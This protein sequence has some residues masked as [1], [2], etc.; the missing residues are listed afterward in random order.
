M[1]LKKIY[2]LFG[3][4]LVI[5]FLNPTS[6]FSGCLNQPYLI[7]VSS[8]GS[9][10]GNS[11]PPS[12]GKINV[13]SD[14][15]D[16]PLEFKI[17]FSGQDCGFEN[18]DIKIRLFKT[19]DFFDVDSISLAQTPKGNM[20]VA[21]K[22]F[23]GRYS[24]SS[25]TQVDIDVKGSRSS[26]YLFPDDDGPEIELID[27]IENLYRSGDDIS[28]N[29]NINDYG[30]L[31]RVIF[32]G[33]Y[34]DSFSVGDSSSFN[35]RINFTIG[36]TQTLVIRARDILGNEVTKKYNFTVDSQGPVISK[37]DKA[38]I[39][40]GGERG[41]N[42]A[43]EVS[44]NS[45]SSSRDIEI[46][47]N[48]SD[49]NSD[50][51][52]LK[53]HRCLRDEVQ[54]DKFNCYWN[55]LAINVENTV[56]ADIRIWA[57]DVVGNENTQTFREEIY[58]DNE[59]PKILA[60]EVVNYLGNKNIISSIE[61]R[62]TYVYLK[63]KDRS[64][65]E[66]N[67]GGLLPEVKFGMLGSPLNSAERTVNGDTI[68]YVWNIT[69]ISRGFMGIDSGK[70]EFSV[71]VVDPYSNVASKNI[72]VI[73]DNIIPGI[74]SI[75]FLETES[76][77]DGVIKS[78]ERVNFKVIVND[79]NLDYGR[80]D[81]NVYSD[82]Y[83][84]ST[85]HKSNEKVMADCGSSRSEGSLYVCN[86]NNVIA[87]NGYELEN[88]SFFAVDKAGNGVVEKF[89]VEILKIA[90]ETRL[91]YEIIDLNPIDSSN[92]ANVLNIMNPINRNHLGNEVVDAWFYGELKLKDGDEA[93]YTILNYDLRECYFVDEN[94][95]LDVGD[96]S[97]YPPIRNGVRNDSEFGLKIEML[98]HPAFEDMNSVEMMCIMSILKRDADSIYGTE[99]EENGE[100]L[101]FTLKIDFYAEPSGDIVMRKA[102][103]VKEYMD[104]ADKV[105]DII[106]DFWDV[107][108]TMDK[109]C[110]TVS[111]FST[112]TDKIASI[113][114]GL[115]LIKPWG[116]TMRGAATKMNGADGSLKSML[117]TGVINGMCKFVSCDTGLLELTGNVNPVKEVLENMQHAVSEFA[118]S[119]TYNDE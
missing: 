24:I 3:F 6:A 90:D 23:F 5:S 118:C 86:F 106:G 15:S 21:T 19:G 27:R 2:Y 33:P 116:E 59:A 108:E 20:S 42:I 82:L 65:L 37:L 34:S 35:K 43:V 75:E 76:I 64:L 69:E 13:K 68:E 30:L 54:R 53:A 89:E 104:N 70:E 50:F 46:Y 67:S 10:A 101:N 72:N 117:N 78:G 40:D 22:T 87:E 1:S 77:E 115:A 32:S 45:F 44:D 110:R 95:T 7:E 85:N 62:N 58:V 61:R 94:I 103:R 114:N 31:D 52:N 98:N 47:G 73:I 71:V 36:S 66:E 55:N 18:S 91:V 81:F 88:V 57:R 17:I 8:G 80:R 14:I 49:F 102:Q 97:F 99:L 41:V 105:E 12:I 83:L 16:N 38:Y 48:F 107:Y 29:F 56:K 96:E 74:E 79:S 11:S 100:L 51:E 93:N 28:L 60:F 84:I 111:L 26:F 92:E 109:V 39:N 113:L 9:F 4:L 119:W 112:A 63:I 25:P